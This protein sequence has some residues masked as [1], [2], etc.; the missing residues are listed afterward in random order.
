MKFFVAVLPPLTILLFIL[1]FISRLWMRLDKLP[2]ITNDSSNSSRDLN[3]RIYRNFEFF[4][5]IFLALV[6]GFGFVKFTYGLTQTLLAQKM[7]VGIGLI[8]M[9]TMVALVLSVASIQGWK[10]LR[11]N[12][13]L[14]GLLWTWQEIYMMSAMYILATALWIAVILW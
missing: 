2:K 7:L 4:V 8:G 6:G 5:K 13:V 10:I 12:P 14:W 11:W 3:D 1:L 9:I